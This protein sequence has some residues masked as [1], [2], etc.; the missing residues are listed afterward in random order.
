MEVAKNP[1]DKNLSMWFKYLETKNKLATRLQN[2]MAEYLSKHPN[3]KIPQ[4]TVKG[5]A[6]KKQSIS[7]VDSK[8][9]RIRMYFESTCPHCKRMMTSLKKLQTQGYFIE[10]FQI[11]NTKVSKNLFPIATVKANPLDVKKYG[12]KSV[13][14]TLIADLKGKTVSKPI[15]GY[16]SAAQLKS[17]M[18]LMTNKNGG[19]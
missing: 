9:F 13:P 12:I 7:K 10:A 3:K 6:F 19:K 11:D 2:R 5:L 8:R 16:Q 18:N 15:T 14:F 1:T 17:I 4:S